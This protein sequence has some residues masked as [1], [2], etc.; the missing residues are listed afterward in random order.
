[1][2]TRANPVFVL[3]RNKLETTPLPILDTQEIT[4]WENIEMSLLSLEKEQ[5]DIL[6][7]DYNSKTREAIKKKEVIT[8]RAA[9]DIKS[10]IKVD[11]D[12]IK[13]EIIADKSIFEME[14]AFA[15]GDNNSLIEMLKKYQ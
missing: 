8:L 10:D 12:S 14:K 2:N 4:S 13:D 5:F 9:K 6:Y 15:E 1:M 7:K 3:V 11:I